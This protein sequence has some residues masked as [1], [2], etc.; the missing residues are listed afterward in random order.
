MSL[1]SMSTILSRA[2]QGNYGVGAFSVANM[3]MIM[4]AIQAAEECSSPI[5]LQVA[6]VRLPYSPLALLGPMMLAAAKEASVPVAV[7]FDHG[8][9]IEVIKEALELG[10]TSVMMDASHLPIDQNIEMV[11]KVKKLADNYGASVEAEVGQLGGSEDGSTDLEMFFSDPK[12]VKQLYEQTG[13]D[14]VAL[15]IGNAHGLYKKEPKLKFSIL[16]ETKEI[17]QVPLVL[18]GGSGISAEDFRHCIRL[19]IRKVNIA[20]ANFLSVEAAARD[21]CR[22]DKR[23]YFKL[24]ASM[25][26]GMK[27]NVIEH[28][29]IFQSNDKAWR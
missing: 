22:E 21:Y 4:G 18:H 19:G 7:H 25:V 13:V 20:T 12:E 2:E 23:D 3:E 1:V 28:I 6:E 27:R 9:S 8:L 11:K 24:S 15:S 14:A 5:I 26:Q 10:F 29:N 16:E 17:V